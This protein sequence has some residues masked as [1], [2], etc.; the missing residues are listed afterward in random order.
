MTGAHDGVVDPGNTSR[1]AARLHAAGDN[2][3]VLTYSWVGHLS[4][5]G[6]FARPLRF[7]APVLHDVDAFIAKTVQRARSAQH[8]E[9][10]P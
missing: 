5:I 3:T 9:P 8:A 4:I 6:A 1:L 2:V 7:L 10:A